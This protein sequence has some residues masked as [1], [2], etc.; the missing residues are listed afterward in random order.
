MNKK[1]ELWPLVARKIFLAWAFGMLGWAVAAAQAAPPTAVAEWPFARGNPQGTGAVEIQLPEKLAERW[2]YEAGEAI[3]ATVIVAEQTVYIADAM[4]GIHAVSLADGKLRWRAETELGFLAPPAVSDGLLVVGDIDGVVYAF[5]AKTGER[6]WTFTTASEINAGAMFYG[7][8]VLVSSQDGNLYALKASDGSSVWTYETSDQ[9]QCTP[10]IAGSRTF[11]GGCDGQLHTVDLTTG[12]AAAEPLPLGG[13]TLSTPA[14]VGD[15][16]FL[17]THGGL[18]LAFDWKS[19]KRLWEFDD[20]ERNQE[21]RSSPAAT[22]QTV[23]VASQ[24]RKV[25]A[26]DAET[27]EPRWSRMLRRFAEAS[28]VIAGDDVWIAATD[29]RLYRFALSDGTP[30]WEYELRGSFQAAPVVVDG[31]LLVANDD[32][33]VIAFAGASD[34]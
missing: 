22:E 28:P 4:G 21:Y 18:V 26:L 20:P 2:R 14:V 31:H 15:R 17:T 27:G 32:G 34:E 19:N 33:T 25:I 29:G 1:T 12:K 3:D 10:T 9:I 16:A 23:V 7:D 6:R 13:P 8:H 11:L 30:R 24:F 5:D